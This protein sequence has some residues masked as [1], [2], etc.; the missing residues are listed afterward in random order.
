MISDLDNLFGDLLKIEDEISELSEAF[1][2]LHVRLASVMTNTIY[3]ELSVPFPL[4]DALTQEDLE[5]FIDRVQLKTDDSDYEIHIITPR[6][7]DSVLEVLGLDRSVDYT[8]YDKIIQAMLDQHNKILDLLSLMRHE[9]T[10]TEVYYGQIYYPKLRNCSMKFSIDTDNIFIIDH[11]E[12]IVPIIYKINRI[13]EIE[14]IIQ[15]LCLNSEDLSF[16]TMI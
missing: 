1:E 10:P 8:Y 6:H 2:G 4:L 14:H 13:H 5:P 9:G 12:D 3:Y 7:L 16:Y 15:H 11:S